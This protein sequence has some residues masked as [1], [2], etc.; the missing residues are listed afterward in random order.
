MYVAVE[1]GSVTGAVGPRQN[2]SSRKSNRNQHWDYL[3]QAPQSQKGTLRVVI[4]RNWALMQGGDIQDV[5]RRLDRALQVRRV[6]DLLFQNAILRMA[7]RDYER[8]RLDAEECSGASQRMSE[9]LD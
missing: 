8:A 6:R 3:D 4:E 1:A 7:V 9:L 2:L 5:R